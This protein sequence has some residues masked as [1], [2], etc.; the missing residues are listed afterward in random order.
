[1]P[2]KLTTTHGK[3]TSDITDRKILLI[4]RPLLSDGGL[5]GGLSP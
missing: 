5:E 4:V 2:S 1:M 3:K